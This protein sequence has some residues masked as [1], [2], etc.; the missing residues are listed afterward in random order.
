MRI[1]LIQKAVSLIFLSIKILESSFE[2]IV[3]VLVLSR[4]ILA[5]IY[6]CKLII[7]RSRGLIE[8]LDLLV[9]THHWWHLCLNLIWIHG[10]L[11]HESIL[12]SSHSERI[13]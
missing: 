11:E 8:I 4:R 5:H 13:N 6:K 3:D 1:N 10:F 2:E 9:N 12:G 7:L